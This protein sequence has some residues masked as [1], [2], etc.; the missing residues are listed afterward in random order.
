MMRKRKR[1]KKHVCGP[2]I[3][4]VILIALFVWVLPDALEKVNYPVKYREWIEEFA[5][6]YAVDPALV[7]A[8]VYTESG[9]DVNATSSVGARGLMQVM[10]STAEWIHPK[11]NKSYA[12]DAEVLYT[13]DGALSYGC[14]YLGFLTDLFDDDRMSVIAAYHAGQG[15]VQSWRN[16]SS[17]APDGVHLVK[18]PNGAAA[19][20]H[21]V[22]KVNKAYEYYSKVYHADAND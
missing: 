14:W 12:F 6:E 13:V 11:L 19:T 1:A 16:D 8:I 4:L 21:Y 22:E 20:R 3:V 2:L 5:S 10:P 18:I 17:Y 9:Y 7:A 15:K